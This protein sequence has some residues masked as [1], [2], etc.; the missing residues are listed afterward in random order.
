MV[1]L[2]GGG[3][4]GHIFPNLAVLERLEER[5]LPLKPHFLVSGRV[6][7]RE[8][9]TREEVAFTA[10]P[11]QPLSVRPWHW[12]A[13]Y[14]GW[15]RSVREVTALLTSNPV[16]AVV[17]TGGFVSAPAVYAASKLGLPVALLNLDA[18][19]GRANSLMRRYATEL[20][21]AYAVPQWPDATPIGVPLRRSAVGT[22]LSP[23]EART[24]LGLEPH[25]DT[26]LV[27]G[28]SQASHSINQMM[29]EL[30]TMAPSRRQL[31]TWQVLHLSGPAEV[32]ALRSAYAKAQIPARV[33]A[34]CHAMGLA[35]RAATIAISRAGAGSVAEVWA[36]AVP[37]VFLPYPYH[38]DQHQRLNAKPLV[39]QGAAV[40]M[41]DRIDAEVNARA[42]AGPI[43]ALMNNAPR[44][45][46][47]IEQM[48]RT[49]PPDGAEVVARWIGSRK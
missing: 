7:D 22:N 13:F 44:R 10:L 32:D 30:V 37:T 34:F 36:N 20:F 43:S 33:E 23:Q 42:L 21:S 1:V 19:P 14:G 48:Q 27:T 2:A 6:L 18:A 38:R 45:L 12:P 25:R 17:A 47:M 16:A 41:D 9:L 24:Q 5:G 28:A 11:A 35:W 26:L 39:A 46:R 40:L 8:L 4:G 3:S 49:A 31:S 15:R 29:M